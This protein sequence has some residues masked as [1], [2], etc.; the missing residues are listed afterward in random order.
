MH[1]SIVCFLAF[2]YFRFAISLFPLHFRFRN[3][4]ICA[5][6]FI[7]YVDRDLSGSG[8]R[9]GMVIAVGL[10]LRRCGGLPGR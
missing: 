8:D 1:K 6:C 3:N 4:A 9:A 5:L 10:T 7:G 2:P